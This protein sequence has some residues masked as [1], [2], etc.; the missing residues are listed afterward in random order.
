MSRIEIT[1]T[2]ALMDGGEE[3]RRWIFWYDDRVNGLRCSS[4]YLEHRR[5]RQRKFRITEEWTQHR[6]TRN[7]DNIPITKDVAWSALEEF[8]RQLKIVPWED[9]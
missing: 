3:R 5:P 4:A 6:G 2:H 1:R 7:P 9:R 8:K